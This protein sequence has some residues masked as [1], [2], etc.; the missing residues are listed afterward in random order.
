MGHSEGASG[1]AALV[2]VALSA[3]ERTLPGNLHFRSTCHE[4]ILAGRIRVVAST[5]AFSGGVV[6]V[7]N[8]GFGGTNAALLV[9]DISPP[10]SVNDAATRFV[11]GRT[12]RALETYASSGQLSAAY[13]RKLLPSASDLRRFPFRGIVVNNSG[14]YKAEVQEVSGRPQLA[15]SFTGQGSQWRGMAADMW[16][17]DEVFRATL[18]DACVGLPFDPEELFVNGDR[19]LDKAWSGLGITLVQLGLVAVLREQGIEPDFLLGHSVGE[20]ACG[21]ADGST[22]AREAAAIAYVRCRLSDRITAFGEMVAVGMSLEE[23]TQLIAPYPETVVACHNSPDGVTLSGPSCDIQ[24]LKEQLEAEGRFVRRV[25]TD[26]IAYH[27][28]FFRRHRKEIR[29]VIAEAI[30]ENGAPRPLRSKRWLST[31][32]QAEHPYAD[33]E[34]HANNIANMVE[35]SPA[36]ASLPAGTIVVEVGPRPLLRSVI[37]RCNPDLQVVSCMVQGERGVD[38]MRRLVDQ[39]W[40][41]G[42]TLNL[43]RMHVPLPLSQRV[44]MLW[45]HSASWRVADYKDFE[46]SRKTLVTYDLAGRDAFLMDHVIDGRPLFPAAGH[47]YSAWQAMGSSSACFRDIKILKAVIMSGESISFAVDMEHDGW[48]IYHE[49]DLVCVGKFGKEDHSSPAALIPGSDAS[50]VE[51]KTG[52]TIYRS[53]R[54]SGYDYGSSFQIISSRSLDHSRLIFHSA[55]HWIPYLDGFLQAGIIDPSGTRLPT[56]IAF[57]SLR[58]PDV[59][60]AGQNI[61]H[62]VSSRTTRSLNVTLEGL[63]TSLTRKVHKPPILRAVRFVPYGEHRYEF[64]ES[65]KRTVLSRLARFVC[66]LWAFKEDLRDYDFLDKVHKLS[67]LTG[68]DFEYTNGHSEYNFPLLRIIAHLEAMEPKELLENAYL[69]I[70]VSEGHEDLYFSDPSASCI[71]ALHGLQVFAQILRESLLEGYSVLEVGGG[72][73]GLTRHL[74]PLIEADVGS[75]T[76]S[77]VSVVQQHFDAV[78]VVRYDVNDSWGG[79]AVDVIAA[80]NAIHTCRNLTSSLKNLYTALT[81]GGFLILHEYISVLPALLWGLSSFAFSAEDHRDFALW[82]TKERWLSLLKDNGF[83]PITW[84]I[85]GGESQL[86]LLARKVAYLGSPRVI[87]HRQDITEPAGHR[88]CLH[89]DDYGCLGMV[90]ALRREPGYENVILRLSVDGSEESPWPE[91]GLPV[92]VRK[93][94]QV[95]GVHETILESSTDGVRGARAIVRIPGDLST[96]GWVECAEAPTCEVRYCGLNFKDAMLA[97][98]RLEHEGEVA[99]GLE[100]SGLQGQRRVMGIAQGCMGTHVSCPESMLWTLPDDVAFEAAATIPVVYATAYFA[101]V[102]KAGISPGQ[103]VLIHSVAGG[104]GQAALRICRSRGV[105]VI[106]SCSAAKVDWAAQHLGL[107]PD[108]IVDSHSTRFKQGVQQITN[109]EGVDVWLGYSDHQYRLDMRLGGVKFTCRRPA[110]RKSGLPSKVWAFL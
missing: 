87:H 109:G 6:A 107:H 4:P 47:I 58:C 52:A 45:D 96:M 11:F 33:A 35:F 30:K 65:Y 76:T 72:S 60:D 50:A 53:F 16:A 2:K 43:P 67:T 19:W 74:F 98:G 37:Q 86:L 110:S 29:D 105:R 15:F 63:R 61:A 77:D 66:R 82:V 81:D 71:G 70:S 80:S 64:E 69:A 10:T 103:T 26:G 83:E 51:M 92:L 21:F 85:D 12:R 89:T 54:R 78:K 91:S 73:G 8:F 5:E 1:L 14:K 93:N 88:L 57:V 3:T 49:D 94:G 32:G 56:E 7:S 9:E 17:E 20:V 31:S 25:E 84:Y 23:A 79:E 108:Y 90:R 41:S 102:V 55:C 59:R 62:D 95:G 27:S 24:R 42:I 40:L 22:S 13:W 99:L 18:K 68:I 28:I 48:R 100:F 39:L 97:Y 38:S 46:G 106:G 101:L 104:V 34:Y 75:Y 36:V 44:P